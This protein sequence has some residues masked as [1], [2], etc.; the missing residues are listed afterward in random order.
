M[1]DTNYD[2]HEEGAVIPN[3]I[4]EGTGLTEGQ[5]IEQIKRNASVT[6]HIPVPGEKGV[7]EKVRVDGDSA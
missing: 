2:H 3:H 5:D 1:K 6:D 4:L 7:D